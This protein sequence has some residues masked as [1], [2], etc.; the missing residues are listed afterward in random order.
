MKIKSIAAA[1]AIGL[2]MGFAGLFVGAGTASAQCNQ[3]TTP[4][5][6]RAQCLV[7]A[8]I[9]GFLDSANPVNQVNT[10]LNGTDTET[11]VTERHRDRGLRDQQ[12]RSWH[13]RSA[14]H[15]RGQ[16]RG[17]GGFLVRTHRHL[18]PQP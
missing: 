9:A 16:H 13:P 14:R 7:N 12:R 1:G 10:F 15:L 17:R 11:C 5:L 18:I 6:E 2:G 4:P 8:D 3:A